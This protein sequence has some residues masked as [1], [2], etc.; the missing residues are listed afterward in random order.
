MDRLI[1]EQEKAIRILQ[2]LHDNTYF[3]RLTEEDVKFATKYAIKAI[4]AIPSTEPQTGHWMKVKPR[5][6]WMYSDIYS[7]CDQC[8]EITQFGWDYKFCPHCGIRMG[9]G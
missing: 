9:K 4:K 3:F 7:E 1:S 2:W 6:C 5:G 8:H